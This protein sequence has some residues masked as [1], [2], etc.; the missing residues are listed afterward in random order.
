MDDQL[1]YQRQG[2]WLRMARERAG[3]SQSGA[4]QEIGLAAASKSTISD[5]ERGAQPA[6]QQVLRTLARWYAVPVDLFQKPPI[7]SDEVIEARL[8]E[9]A[10]RAEDAERQD[11]QE[12]RDRSQEDDDERPDVPD[13]RSA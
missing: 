13:T 7:T 8:R 3:K 4:A 11:W 1:Y 5:Y 12:G 10:S 6:P 2:F 9:L